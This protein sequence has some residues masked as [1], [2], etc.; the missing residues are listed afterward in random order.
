MIHRHTIAPHSNCSTSY[1]HSKIEARQREFISNTKKSKNYKNK[2]NLWSNTLLKPFSFLIHR[3]A[4]SND[5]IMRTSII[6]TY[7]QSI[8]DEAEI[9][10]NLLYTRWL[11]VRCISEAMNYIKCI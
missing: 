5:A 8:R 6:N 7:T 9:R 1:S 3:Y 10:A 4:K 11:F 2:K